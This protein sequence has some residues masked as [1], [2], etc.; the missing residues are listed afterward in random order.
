VLIR[1]TF[2]ETDNKGSAPLFADRSARNLI[3][4]ADLAENPRVSSGEID[5]GAYENR[6][7]VGTM[8]AFK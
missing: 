7:T 1:R 2:T 6:S 3:Y 5:A 8:F 4:T